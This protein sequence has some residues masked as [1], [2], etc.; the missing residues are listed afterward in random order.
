MCY[1]RNGIKPFLNDYN[2]NCSRM[3]SYHGGIEP[4]GLMEPVEIAVRKK[5]GI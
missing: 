3:S 1:R 5:I 2:L 4:H